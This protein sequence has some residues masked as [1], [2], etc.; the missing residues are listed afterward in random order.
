VDTA[1]V[2]VDTSSGET[3]EG[4]AGDTAEE[5]T[6]ET[7]T[8]VTSETGDTGTNPCPTGAAHI[9]SFCIDL[10][11][12]PN[13]PGAA[14]LIMYT[15]DESADWCAA[16]GRR[17]CT[18]VEWERACDGGAGRDYPYGDEHDPGVCNDE[19]T[20]IV[21]DQSLLNGWPSSASTAD[22]ES[23]DALLAAVRVVSPYTADHVEALYQGEG[24]GDNTGCVSEGVYDLTGNVEEWT[25]RADGGTS[26]FTGNLKGRYWSETR[27]CGSD[28]T[29]HGDSFRFYEIGFR[30]CVDARSL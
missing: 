16:R 25:R 7:T 14:P 8:P 13:K 3:G 30:C 11:E 21:Y 22:V 2:S 9:D 12:A 23:L 19:E 28:I 15:L 4:T 26:G 18:D 29:S 1:H 17:L 6:E 27:T 24:S 10:Y 20:W 5:T